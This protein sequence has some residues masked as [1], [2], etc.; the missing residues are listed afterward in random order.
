MCG[1][2]RGELCIERRPGPWPGRS[3]LSSAGPECGDGARTESWDFGARRRVRASAP[4]PAA[5]AVQSG[6]YKVGRAFLGAR[7]RLSRTR[8][9]GGASTPYS[10][11]DLGQVPK[12]PASRPSLLGDRLAM[13]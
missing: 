13:S 10:L 7:S 6:F 11:S 4:K 12:S 8:W 5:R 9:S 1:R 2:R 3:P